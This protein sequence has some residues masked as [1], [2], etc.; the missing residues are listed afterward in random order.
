MND[1]EVAKRTIVSMIFGGAVVYFV[2]VAVW[3][4]SVIPDG[5]N[6]PTRLYEPDGRYVLSYD[7]EGVK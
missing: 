2:A 1:R 7:C 3:P 6:S 4:D 5:C